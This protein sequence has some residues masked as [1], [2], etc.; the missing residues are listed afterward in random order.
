MYKILWID[1]QHRDEEMIQ[2]I[3][4]ADNEGLKLEGYSSAEEGF[5]V[6]ESNLERFD[7]ILLDGLFFEK[8]DQD[9]GTEDES[10]I[11]LAIAKINEL[12]SKKVFQWFVLSGKDQFTKSK[13]SLLTANK[14]RCYDKTNPTDV[15]ELFLQLK[16]AAENQADTQLRHKYSQVLEL[17]NDPYLGNNQFGRLFNLIKVIENVEPLQ[18]TGDM[19]NPLRKILEGVFTRMSK[20]GIIPDQ[21]VSN[22]GWIN[23]SSLFLSNRHNDYECLVEIVPPLIAENL[24][25]LLNITQDASHSEGT[26]KLKVNDYLK[27]KKN[28]Y[29]YRSC[30]YLLFDLLSWFKTFAD[31]HTD[32]VQ[33]KALWRKKEG[34]WIFGIVTKIQPNG[35]GTFTQDN[36]TQTLGIKPDLVK[37]H[38]LLGGERVKVTTKLSSDG[39]KTH[40]KELSMELS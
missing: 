36:S 27:D 3:I 34:D 6:L 21:I 4:D 2:F 17:C 33:N 7:A 32:I 19:L 28:D 23:G 37:Q 40:I 5:E 25:R 38:L 35:Y 10:G 1:D 14:V 16:S 29:L 12:K 11:G 30:I 8:K 26:L 13:N 39:N 15:V 20:L 31:I 24:H 18:N 9:A 22:N